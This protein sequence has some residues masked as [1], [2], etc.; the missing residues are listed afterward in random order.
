[1]NIAEINNLWENDYNIDIS[2]LS[3]EA[4]NIPK[5][6][7]KYLTIYGR[8]YQKLHL[9][10]SELN[11]LKEKKKYFL[12]VDSTEGRELGWIFPNQTVLKTDFNDWLLADKEYSKLKLKTN[13]QETKIDILKRILKSI[14]TRQFII[15]LLLDE[16]KFNHGS[17]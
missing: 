10:Q 8:E 12:Y 13:I 16:K 2:D 11:T 17:F 15:K 6:M 7:T 1:V 3:S 14:D 5:L 4:I 9:L